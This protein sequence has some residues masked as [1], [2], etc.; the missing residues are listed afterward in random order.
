LNE[1]YETI[2][3]LLEPR[4]PWLRGAQPVYRDFRSGDVRLSQAGIDKAQRLLGYEP[5]WQVRDGLARAIDWY[6]GRAP[7]TRSQDTAAGAVPH[8]MGGALDDIPEAA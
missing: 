3:S 2:R 5:A 8:G 7:A 4:C 1:L 6:A